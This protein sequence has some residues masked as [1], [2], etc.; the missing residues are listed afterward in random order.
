MKRNSK[1]I[2]IN[3]LGK[4]FHTTLQGEPQGKDTDKPTRSAAHRVA[5]L[6]KK[7]A[8]QMRKAG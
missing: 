3:L 4:E 8:S 7:L 2:K 5:D 6:F 1:I